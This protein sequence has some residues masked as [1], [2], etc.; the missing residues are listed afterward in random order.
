[1]KKR[2]LFIAANPQ[3]LAPIEWD[4]E[5]K[6][7]NNRLKRDY[8]IDLIPRATAVDLSNYEHEEYWL[9]HFTGHGKDGEKIVLEQNTD[10]NSLVYRKNDFINFISTIRDLKCVL[11]SACDTEKLV[12]EMKEKD[13]YVIAFKGKIFNNDAIAFADKFYKNLSIY[14]T[15]PFAFKKTTEQLSAEKY[16]GKGKIEPI[17]TSKYQYIMNKI[18]KGQTN[19][20]KEKYAERKDILKEI[21]LLE[22]DKT[23]VDTLGSANKDLHNLF[24]DLL[25]E[26]PYPHGTFWFAENKERLAEQASSTLLYDID[27][28]VQKYFIKDFDT[29]LDY[30]QSVLVTN[31]FQEYTRNDID[32]SL[33]KV[34]DIEYYKRGLDLLPTF[35]PKDC[36]GEFELYFKLS[37]DYIKGLL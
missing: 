30:L 22:E 23:L 19:D 34:V 37:C 27:I 15:I 32:V 12:T 16:K 31:D 6:V 10:R 18:L 25:K 26:S 11:I 14:Q 33:V 36:K 4:A 28:T 24:Y 1:M 7:M 3:D 8:E 2:V 21:E 5:F 35:I 17:F 9:I 29:L 20:L 13:Y